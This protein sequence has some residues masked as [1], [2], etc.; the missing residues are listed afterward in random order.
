MDLN[1]AQ[2]TTVVMVLHDLNMAARYSDHLIALARGRM[3]ACGP[4][5]QILD[6]DLVKSVFGM[7]SQ[8]ITDPVSGT[9][10][11]VPMGRHHG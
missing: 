2:G 7:Q 4:P 8:L 1:R 9:P 11:M 6:V 5:A 3:H 10:L